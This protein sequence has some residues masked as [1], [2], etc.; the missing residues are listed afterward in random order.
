MFKPEK[1]NFLGYIYI[2]LYPDSV[3]VEVSLEP[4][5]VT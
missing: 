1:D 5:F 4:N 3:V 2:I